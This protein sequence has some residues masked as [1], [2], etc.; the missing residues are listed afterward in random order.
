MLEIMVYEGWG[1]ATQTWGPEFRFSEFMG[2]A[3]PDQACT[4]NSTVVRGGGFLDSSLAL[5]SLRDPMKGSSPLASVPMHG[6]TTYTQTCTY[7][8]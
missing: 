8:V 3:R 2:K 6:Y 7:T 4:G 1:L 5:G